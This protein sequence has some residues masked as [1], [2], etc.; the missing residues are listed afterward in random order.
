MKTIIKATGVELTPSI[1]EYI[2][3][4][5]SHLDKLTN[6][7]EDAMVEV[8]VGK[9]TKHH[10]NGEVMFSEINL[11]LDGKLFRRVVKDQD[12]YSAIDQNKDKIECDIAS[13][14]KKKDR[15][16]RRGG[17]AV[18]NFIKGFYRKSY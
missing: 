18:K 3:T 17:R 4:K 5:M 16:F 11:R 9:I 10:K 15:L 13:Y 6:S 7:Y 1:S 12:L 14:L 2:K 8:E